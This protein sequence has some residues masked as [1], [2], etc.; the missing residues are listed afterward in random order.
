M[1]KNRRKE[2]Q[3]KNRKEEKKKEEKKKR[4]KEEK[5]KRRNEKKKKRKKIMNPT[6]GDLGQNIL[7]KKRNILITLIQ[8]QKKLFGNCQ[9]IQ[10]RNMKEKILKVKIKKKKNLRQNQKRKK[11]KKIP[12]TRKNQKIEG[13]PRQGAEIAID[14]D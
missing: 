12:T 8:L 11:L 3:K 14:G 5:K 7:I 1:G 2:E 6:D 13:P 10:K 9:K 4:R